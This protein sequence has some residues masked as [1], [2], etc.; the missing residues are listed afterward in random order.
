MIRK[1]LGDQYFNILYVAGMI[2]INQNVNACTLHSP[3]KL[4][5]KV[6]L[7][8][9]FWDRDFWV[10]FYELYFLC[11][12]V[13]LEKEDVEKVEELSVD[14]ATDVDHLLIAQ[15]HLLQAAPHKKG[16]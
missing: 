3:T 16:H 15:H 6:V 4:Q 11:F 5:K 13:Y 1:G 14:I 8:A 10:V 7:A 12:S 9:N 2:G